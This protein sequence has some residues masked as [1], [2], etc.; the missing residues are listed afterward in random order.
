[1]EILQ[2]ARWVDFEVEEVVLLVMKGRRSEAGCCCV[3]ACPE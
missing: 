1:M 2:G 3:F